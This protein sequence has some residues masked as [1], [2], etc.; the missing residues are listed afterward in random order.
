[1][2]AIRSYYGLSIQL[3]RTLRVNIGK[4]LFAPLRQR[5]APEVRMVISG[6]AAL[7]PA[8]ARKLE[9]L[10]WQVATGYGLTETSPILTFN[11]PGARRFDNAGRPLPGVELRIVKAET[12]AAFG[13]VLAKGANVFSGYRHL[14]Q[15]NGQAFT[16]DGW[17]RTGDLGYVDSKGYRNNF[18]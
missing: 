8:L 16:A 1:M 6:G 2:Y 9:G 5:F 7:E 17:F 3:R 13:E 15:L 10:G 12:P 14:P 11:P 4:W 18:V